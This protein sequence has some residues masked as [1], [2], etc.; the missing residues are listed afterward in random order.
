MSMK[1]VIKLRMEKKCTG[2]GETKPLEEY[3]KKKSGKYGR[4]AKCKLCM[5]AYMKA[6][7][8]SEE[9]KAYQ[10]KYRESEKGKAYMKTL[11]GKIKR[12]QEMNLDG[13]GNRLG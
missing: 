7:N 11:V 2:C 10:K 8:Q 9:R 4:C 13:S 6:Y 1:K 5:N 12:N 3:H